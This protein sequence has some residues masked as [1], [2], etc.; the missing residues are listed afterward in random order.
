MAYDELLGSDSIGRAMKLKVN[1]NFRTA[2]FLNVVAKSATFVAFADDVDGAPVDVYEL[3]VATPYEV[4]LPPAASHAGRVLTLKKVDAALAAFTIDPDGS[5]LIDG[6]SSYVG[7]TSQWSS[8]TIYSNGTGWRVV[9][10]RTSVGGGSGGLAQG[11]VIISTDFTNLAFGIPLQFAASG[12]GAA[13]NAG[14]PEAGRPGI[15]EFTTGTTTSGAAL[16]YGP[17]SIL[18][19]GIGCILLGGGAWYELWGVKVPTLS[20][21]GER[22]IVLFG[23]SDN[24]SGAPTD[25]VWIEYDEATSANWRICAASNTTTTKTT[26]SVAVDTNW[27]DFT[28]IINAAGTS[29]EY[30]IDGT[31]LGVV[32]TNVPNGAGRDTGIVGRI[33]KSAGTTART[34][35]WDYLDISA[36]LTTPRT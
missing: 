31:S 10:S 7:S 17:S 22:F 19:G 11:S 12:A 33:M 9:G 30:F 5:E 28:I 20:T 4:D 15:F 24:A 14:T 29:A 6:A 23:L 8:V 3:T 18:A 21:A 25:G 1:E 26:T 16:M 13:G 35:L 36:S 32:N 27:H 34:V 2:R